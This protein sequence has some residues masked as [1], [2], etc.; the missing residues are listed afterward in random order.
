M[1]GQRRSCS[2]PWKHRFLLL[3]DQYSD[4][5]FEI[6][7]V[8]RGNVNE[9]SIFVF[10][11]KTLVLERHS[12][13]Y[14]EHDR[15]FLT[16]D[17]YLPRKNLSDSTM[18]GQSLHLHSESLDLKY[19]TTRD[20]LDSID[21]VVKDVPVENAFFGSRFTKSDKIAD[22]V[23]FADTV[24]VVKPVELL[25]ENEID[26]TVVYKCE[27]LDVLDGELELDAILVVF[28]A[29]S[30]KT[31]TDY[32]VNAVRVEPNS[33]IFTL[34]SRENSVAKLGSE[35]ASE[36]TSLTSNADRSKR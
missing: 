34:A 9:K 15:Y 13:V 18:Y 3:Y 20:L 1:D 36:F 29:E 19:K 25:S 11:E 5:E 2:C 22:V 12:L 31:G 14:Y 28:F 26:R 24:L 17:L 23:N 35:L 10:Q 6:V 4:L 32:I 16:G 27:V 7:S 8:L 30:V 21:A 33:L